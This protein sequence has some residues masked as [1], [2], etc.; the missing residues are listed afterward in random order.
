MNWNALA[1]HIFNS[2]AEKKIS[3]LL[4]SA[5]SRIPDPPDSLLVSAESAEG[6]VMSLLGS[7]ASLSGDVHWNGS[8]FEVWKPEVW[9]VHSVVLKLLLDECGWPNVMAPGLSTCSEAP[10]STA[11]EKACRADRKEEDSHWFVNSERLMTQVTAFVKMPFCTSY[12]TVSEY[13]FMSGCC[14]MGSCPGTCAPWRRFWI[15]FW[16]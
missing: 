12:L 13:Q 3:C 5:S 2:L 10:A 16:F 9:N 4:W 11:W 1:H 7:S 15:W 6:I 8:I 14:W